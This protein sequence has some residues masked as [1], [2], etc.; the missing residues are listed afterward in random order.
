MKH[1]VFLT[2]VAVLLFT[3]PAFAQATPTADLITIEGKITVE[4]DKDGKTI[5]SVKSGL[6]D[7]VLA[8]TPALQELLKVEKLAEKQFALEGEKKSADTGPDTF[9]ISSFK[10]MAQ[11]AACDSKDHDHSGHNHGQAPAPKTGDAHEH[12]PGD[13]HKH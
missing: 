12:S 13:G 7:L 2:L 3:G 10:E 9:V 8:D 4:K 11:E 5:A 1:L 6:V